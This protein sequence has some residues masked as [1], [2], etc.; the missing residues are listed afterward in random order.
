MYL[1]AKVTWRISALR[2]PT[3]KTQTNKEL[4]IRGERE[5]VCTG[6]GRE[7]VKDGAKSSQENEETRR[8]RET[9]AVPW[10]GKAPRGPGDVGHVGHYY[11]RC[12]DF[13]YSIV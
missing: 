1:F 11:I 6:E 7:E 9:I 4:E 10:E 5:T 12:I 3:Q 2:R 13:T 8:E